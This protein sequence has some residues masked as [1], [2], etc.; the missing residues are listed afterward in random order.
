MKKNLQPVNGSFK[1]SKYVLLSASF[2]TC[3]SLWGCNKEPSVSME[4]YIG[5]D[6]AKDAALKAADIPSGQASISSAGLENDDG[7]FYY[8]VI[9]TENGTEHT[10]E[11]DA[12][13]GIV[14]KESHSPQASKTLANVQES[15]TTL[16]MSET[17]NTL[18]SSEETS[19]NSVSSD[20]IEDASNSVLPEET[21]DSSAST[22]PAVPADSSNS[23]LPAALSDDRTSNPPAQTSGNT[24]SSGQA[25]STKTVD[26]SSSAKTP[27]TSA[28]LSAQ[29]INSETA[30]SI[31]LTHAGFTKQDIRSSNVKADIEDGIN[32]FDVEFILADG[33]EY[34]YEINA[35]NGSVI[36]YDYD[37]ENYHRQ[38]SSSHTAAITESQAKQTVLNKVPGAKES[39]INLHLEE[40]DGHLEYEGWLIYDNIEYE[41]TIDAYSGTLIEWEAE[42]IRP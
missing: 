13:T 29:G 31:A 21:T 8:E 40:D 15:E 9:F 22:S 39:D 36:K 41:F 5:I 24:D 32:V 11:I 33:T 10:Y 26:S 17:E 1:I 2:F 25:P 4:N 37:A 20:Q 19:S 23:T 28:S 18:S 7:T 30:L 27:D 35:S 16:P 38:H 6:A 34:D 14:I 3:I 12:L 42:Q